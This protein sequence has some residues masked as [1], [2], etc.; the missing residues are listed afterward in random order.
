MRFLSCKDDF[1]RQIVAASHK[2]NTVASQDVHDACVDRG[3][4]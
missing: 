2:K 1:Q 4:A 3:R